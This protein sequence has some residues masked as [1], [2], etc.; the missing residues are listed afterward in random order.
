[1]RLLEKKPAEIGVLEMVLGGRK[2]RGAR[3]ERRCDTGSN[4]AGTEAGIGT[5][6]GAPKGTATG[7]WV[8]TRAEAR[9]GTGPRKRTG[10]RT[11]AETEVSLG[12]LV[13]RCAAPFHTPSR[14]ISISSSS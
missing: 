13:P 5:R 1:M 14:A 7:A 3:E 10:I 12:G 8:G 4:K 11:G 6:A 9:R 2:G